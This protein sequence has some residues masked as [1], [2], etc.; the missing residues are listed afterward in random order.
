MINRGRGWEPGRVGRKANGL[1]LAWRRR[2]KTTDNTSRKDPK[3]QEAIMAASCPGVR[4]DWLGN[5][6]SVDGAGELLVVVR[7][8]DVVGIIRVAEEDDNT[9]VAELT[10]GG[11]NEGEAR[12]PVSLDSKEEVTGMPAGGGDVNSLFEIWSSPLVIPTGSAVGGGI[13]FV[14]A[15]TKLSPFL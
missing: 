11:V 13:P 2:Q 6:D 7:F 5:D 3:T 14:T 9:I 15:G 4:R 1:E 10:E 12:L 8:D